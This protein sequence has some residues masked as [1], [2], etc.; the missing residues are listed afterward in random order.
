VFSP[1]SLALSTR[2]SRSRSCAQS[3]THRRRRA[4]G[5]RRARG[6]KRPGAAGSP[7]R[8]FASLTSRVRSEHDPYAL[9][10]RRQVLAR[11]PH[12]G[13][14][15]GAARVLFAHGGEA[16]LDRG[17]L[18]PERLRLVVQVVALDRVGG[19]GGVTPCWQLPRTLPGPLYV[20][21]APCNTTSAPC[22][23]CWGTPC[24]VRGN[25]PGL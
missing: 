9:L 24:T 25:Y 5:P 22:D 17:H 21:A 19:V 2:S 4:G 13:L 14:P 10:L 18:R 1:S 6:G 3:F 11:P 23:G 8:T 16:A 15:R 12:L 7:G 20:L